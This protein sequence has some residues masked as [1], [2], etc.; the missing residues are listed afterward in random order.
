MSAG[1]IKK[2]ASFKD[3]PELQDQLE[4]FENILPDEA[5]VDEETRKRRDVLRSELAAMATRE[6]NAKARWREKMKAEKKKAVTAL[7]R[8]R[9]EKGISIL[10][11]SVESKTAIRK[12]VKG[13]P[14]VNRMMNTVP[15]LEN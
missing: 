6:E 8:E 10:P 3:Q 12:V 15:S 1:R 9:V 5:E 13:S 11:G 14:L 7:H 2:T 4:P